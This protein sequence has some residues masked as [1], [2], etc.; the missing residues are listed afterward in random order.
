VNDLRFATYI[1]QNASLL[2][3]MKIGFD[4]D[5]MLLERNQIKEELS[6]CPR[7]YAGCNLS[8]EG[9]YIY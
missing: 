5:V 6:S 8:F 1:L 7:I 9:K 4:T 3:D 2:K